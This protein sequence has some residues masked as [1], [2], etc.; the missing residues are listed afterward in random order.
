MFMELCVG[1][2]REMRGAIVRIPREVDGGSELVASPLEVPG[3]CFR[4]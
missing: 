2:R 1:R 3:L 4:G